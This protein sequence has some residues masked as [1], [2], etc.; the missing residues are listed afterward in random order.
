MKLNEAINKGGKTKLYHAS[1]KRFKI[2]KVLVP[3]DQLGK[4]THSVGWGT[5]GVFMTN[6][7]VPHFTIMNLS[8]GT[9]LLRPEPKL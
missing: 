8:Y 5:R 3:G 7:P 4:K 6:K 2:G 1:P 9:I